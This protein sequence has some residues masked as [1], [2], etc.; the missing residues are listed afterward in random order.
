MKYLLIYAKDVSKPP[1]PGNTETIAFRNR[2]SF[3]WYL[4]RH[5]AA[6][7]AIRAERFQLAQV[8]S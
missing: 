8:R 4:L 1:Q 2:L 6:R 7:A 3:W 5:K